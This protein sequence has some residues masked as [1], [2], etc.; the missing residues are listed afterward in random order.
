MTPDKMLDALNELD[1]RF[2]REAREEKA[3]KSVM[4]GRRFTVLIAAVIALMAMTVTA[5]AS[6]AVAGWF[7]YFFAGKAQEE[8]TPAQIEFIEENEQIIAE[9]REE[10][11]WTV[12]L[13]SAISD[14]TKAYFIIGVTAPEG[15]NLEQRV[16]NKTIKDWFGPGNAINTP[17]VSPSI[18]SGSVEGNY[19]YGGTYGW[20]EDGDGLPNTMNMVYTLHLSKFDP[21]KECTLK[22][23]FGP[24]IDF[25]IHI[26]NIVREYDDEEYY[27]ELMNGKYAG[28]TDVMFTHEETQRLNQ[29]E[30]LVEGTWDFT[31]NFGKIGQGVE[32]I[33]KPIT[34][35]AYVWDEEDPNDMF[36]GKQIY[37]EVTIKSFILNPLSALI[38]CDDGSANFGDMYAVMEDGS[39]IL[40]KDYGNSI[41]AETPIVLSEV[42][43]ILMTDGTKIPMPE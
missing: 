7:R 13:C 10:N 15:I 34:L 35:F 1:S 5:F 30:V 22:E 38:Q 3:G 14:G 12:E 36:D 18:P 41:E 39:R 11:G 29:V 25:T 24:D 21:N 26:E 33:A 6:E 19:S 27:Q 42:D 28:Q 40:L 20:R 43:H 2:L 4:K 9:T 37:Q 8:L 16:E 32:L 17:V 31:V 23:P